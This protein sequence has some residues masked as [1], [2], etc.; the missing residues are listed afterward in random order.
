[1]HTD[2]SDDH[3]LKVIWW[4]VGTSAGR[5]NKFCGEGQCLADAGGSYT[6]NFTRHDLSAF[7]II[8]HAHRDNDNNYLEGRGHED[9][10]ALLS[11]QAFKH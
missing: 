10:G 2:V 5:T 8:T 11:Y 4:S 1:M 6:N 3:R 7:I 9:F